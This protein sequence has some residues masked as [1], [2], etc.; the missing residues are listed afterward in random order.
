MF[1]RKIGYFGFIG[2][3]G[4]YALNYLATHNVT[5]LCWIAYFGFFAAFWIAKISIDIPDERYYKNATM[6]KA[7]LGN[8]AIYEMGILF[9]SG[10]LF[11]VIRAYL[12]VFISICFAS[13]IIA[14]AI[15]F[16]I[17]EEG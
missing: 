16:Y 17:L 13:L 11:P 5:D 6:A 1:K 7:F 12:I 2:F 9:I 8:I 4:F 10:V 15:K 14:Y 3:M